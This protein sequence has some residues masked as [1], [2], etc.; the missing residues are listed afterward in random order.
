MCNLDNV[1]THIKN[2][3]EKNMKIQDFIKTVITEIKQG[4]KSAEIDGKSV[5]PPVGLNTDNNAVSYTKSIDEK[6]NVIVANLDFELSLTSS[7]KDDNDS[8]IAVFLGSVSAGSR[9][10]KSAE[11]TQMT[12]VKFTIPI[13]LSECS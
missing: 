10:K 4:I 13:R 3:H 5:L 7:T 11:K 2:Q 6:E 8:G 12:R 9:W 1:K